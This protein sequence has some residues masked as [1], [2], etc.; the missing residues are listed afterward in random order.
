MVITARRNSY[1][2]KEENSVRPVQKAERYSIQSF[3][4]SL[5]WQLTPM[6]RSKVKLVVLFSSPLANIY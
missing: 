4:M 1:K 6:S 3:R 2:R 5:Q